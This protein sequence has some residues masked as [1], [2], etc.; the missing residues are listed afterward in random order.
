MVKNWPAGNQPAALKSSISGPTWFPSLFYWVTNSRGR[1]RPG[2]RSCVN[3][4]VR[5]YDAL[6]RR[7]QTTGRDWW[8]VLG[9]EREEGRESYWRYTRRTWSRYYRLIVARYDWTSTWWTI[10]NGK[11]RPPWLIRSW[12]S[13]AARAKERKKGSYC[14][15]R[16]RENRLGIDDIP[17]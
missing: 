3:R 10:E 4:V 13:G 15:I 5:S 12:L 7:G 2:R 8:N 11:R 9:S 17:R 6:D 1:L 16:S 14:F